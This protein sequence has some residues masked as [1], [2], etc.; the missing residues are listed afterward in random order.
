[1]QVFCINS[2]KADEKMSSRR[3]PRKRQATG[4]PT[5][6]ES[7]ADIASATGSAQSAG[8]STALADYG[9]PTPSRGNRKHQLKTSLTVS[10][11][12]SSARSTRNKH[13]SSKGNSPFEVASA[14]HVLALES[15][16][17]AREGQQVLDGGVKGIA[18][19]GRKR[20]GFSSNSSA[21]KLKN[22]GKSSD[23]YAFDGFEDDDDGDGEFDKENTLA[24]GA[25]AGR[26][27]FGFQRIKRNLKDVVSKKLQLH[28]SPSSVKSYVSDNG[29]EGK[30]AGDDEEEEEDEGDEDE[31]EEEAAE[32]AEMEEEAAEEEDG[33]EE[34]VGEN[35]DG[36]DDGGMD[37]NEGGEGMESL[38]QKPEESV[39]DQPDYEGDQG[40]DG[41]G[42]AGD[43][44]ELPSEESEGR[45]PDEMVVD[46]LTD[47]PIENSGSSTNGQSLTMAGN[48][49]GTP[50]SNNV[51]KEHGVPT[52][53]DKS[54]LR[55]PSTRV[56]QREMGLTP[57]ASTP[58]LRHSQRL[59]DKLGAQTPPVMDTPEIKRLAKRMQ[60]QRKL[61]SVIDAGASDDEDE[62]EEEEEEEEE[63]NE[64]GNDYRPMEENEED[65]DDD[66]AEEEDVPA[67]SG[68]EGDCDR[69]ETVISPHHDMSKS[70]AASP[71]INDETMPLNDKSTNI[72]ETTPN[73][74]GDDAVAD[75]NADEEAEE[76]AHEKYFSEI[77]RSAH[78]SDNTLAKLPPIEYTTLINTLNRIPQKHKKEIE[79]LIALHRL[80]FPQWYFELKSG[81]NLLFYGF[82]SKVELLNDFARKFLRDGPV[83]IIEGFHPNMSFNVIL[84]D[85]LEKVLDPP[86]IPSNIVDQVALARKYF[87]NPEQAKPAGKKSGNRKFQRLYILIHNIDGENLRSEKSQSTLSMLAS[88]PGIHMLASIDHINAHLM[89][90][91]VRHS[92]F[93]WILH[94]ATTFEPYTRETTFENQLMVKANTAELGVRRVLF[95]FKSLTGNAKKVF[96]ILAEYQMEEEKRRRAEADAFAA[97]DQNGDDDGDYQNEGRPKVRKRSGKGKS[98]P[99]KGKSRKGG[100]GSDEDEDLEDADELY[101]ERMEVVEDEEDD[102]PDT[103]RK[104]TR[105]PKKSAP[106][107]VYQPQDLGLRYNELYAKCYEKFIVSNKLQFKTLLGEFKDHRI[108]HF[109]GSTEEDLVYIPL[110][111]ASLQLVLDGMD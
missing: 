23:P 49:K 90:D 63:S 96:K 93:N 47:C 36:F 71:V 77:L 37:E 106:K 10:A 7:D 46:A 35:Q 69:M 91:N 44:M 67:A 81:F 15:Q 55:T 87:E 100:T 64:D 56:L 103:R 25:L 50:S 4:S 3:R 92:R 29:E 22:A 34:E 98:T 84:Q 8:T 99:T 24:A 82:G 89:W 17:R 26:K 75:R 73:A 79:A 97:A 108:I 54:K 41:E 65:K 42:E 105:K 94:D 107:R 33:E 20:P 48:Q 16:R 70:A 12:Q 104:H 78:T 85:L 80:H 43:G 76:P 110:E 31:D 61:A 74:A 57:G 19:S 39:V 86:T 32:E 2:E 109:T 9:E 18:A 58:S 45:Q 52:S 59:V 38:L 5:Q 13:Q 66:E 40:S 28:G 53:A 60:N 27:L 1:M 68:D 6:L 21:Q 62:E 14:D 101:Y 83:M 30:E 95:V 102:E 51:W 72:D 88:I 11:R 111:C